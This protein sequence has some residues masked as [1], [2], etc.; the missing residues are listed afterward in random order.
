MPMAVSAAK[1]QSAGPTPILLFPAWHFTRLE[2][3]VHN[4]HVDP[5]CPS[6]GSFE[7]LVGFDPGPPFS[8]VCRDELS[9]LRYDP[10]PHTPMRL[11]FSEQ[12][13]VK[14]DIADYGLPG[15]ARHE[16]MYEALEAAG[17]TRSRHPGGRL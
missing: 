7:D 6:S 10:N 12:P 4:Q 2:V 17:Y 16:P 1:P 5:A 9:T 15:C 8:Q 13:G 14:V 11:R 3:T